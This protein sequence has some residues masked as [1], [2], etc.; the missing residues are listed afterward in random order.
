MGS[1]KEP[2][3][4]AAA[5]PLPN[6]ASGFLRE[7]EFDLYKDEYALAVKTGGKTVFFSGGRG[8]PQRA[9]SVFAPT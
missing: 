3:S 8:Y 6:T 7:I 2:F 5:R 1:G 4:F 9:L